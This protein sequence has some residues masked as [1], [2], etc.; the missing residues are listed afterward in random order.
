MPQECQKKR[1]MQQE[2]RTPQQALCHW[3]TGFAFLA[4][5]L[6]VIVPLLWQFRTPKIG[7]FE[8]AVDPFFT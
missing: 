4:T 6:S 3:K 1:F 2:Q 8:N 5:F 7:T